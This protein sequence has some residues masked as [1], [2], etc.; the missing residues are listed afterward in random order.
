MHI[1]NDILLAYQHFNI[2]SKCVDDVAVT[3]T[4]KSIPNQK[5]GV[6]KILLRVKMRKAAGP[7]NIP[8]RVLK[9]CFILGGNHQS[10]RVEHEQSA[11]QHTTK[12]K[13]IETPVLIKET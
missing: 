8:V 9:A 5:A 3:E 1:F 11:A 4:M 6:R 2:L 10:C 7:D 12:N 13:S